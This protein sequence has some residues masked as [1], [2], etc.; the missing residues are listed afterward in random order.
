MRH[1][2]GRRH[3]GDLLADGGGRRGRGGLG[4]RG[5]GVH[6]RHDAASR[7]NLRIDGRD[8]RIERD[9]RRGAHAVGRIH[10][11]DDGGVKGGFRLGHLGV[12]G[13]REF[14]DGGDGG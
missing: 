9:A 2:D 11:G 3:R 14:V 6:A 8:G 13:C 4:P 10:D 5:G 12:G 1:G 7:R